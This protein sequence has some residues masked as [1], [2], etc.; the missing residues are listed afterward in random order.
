MTL[1][2]VPLAI[3]TKGES[4]MKLQLSKFCN[5]VSAIFANGV[6]VLL[7]AGLLVFAVPAAHADV[8]YQFT[9][10]HC[11][12]TCGTGPFGTVTLTQIGANVGFVVD[13]ADGVSWA[14]TGSADFQLFKFNGTGIVAGDISVT[15]TFAGQTLAGTA[16]A[17][18]GGFNGDGTGLFSFGIACTTCGN[19]ALGLSSNLVF[20]VAN[21]TIAELTAANALG[22]IFV[23]DILG[24]NGFTG[25]VDVSTPPICTGNCG[26]PPGGE[27]PE[28][29]TLAL[30]GVALA[31]LGYSRRRRA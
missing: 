7:S 14:Q 5:R 12:N 17:V 10:D 21:A 20:T 3:S 6:R 19:G 30:F 2:S 26:V 18:P 13:L 8:V 9:S 22:N 1:A 24:T 23:A 27:A 4:K 16:A 28:P 31:A 25:P 29:E 15:Q 11:T